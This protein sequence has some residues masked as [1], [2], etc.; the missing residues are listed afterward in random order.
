LKNNFTIF[1]SWQSDLDPKKNKNFISTV[2][3]KAIKKSK[4]HSDKIE[5][6]I[7]IDRDTKNKSGA[8]SI[9]DSIF[10][11][12]DNC[13]IFICDI[14]I[15]NKNWYTG[16]LKKRLTPN[17]NVLIELGYAVNLLGWERIICLNNI[18]ISKNE[19]LPF[20]IRSHRITN[21]NPNDIDS[22]INILKSAIDFTIN[23]YENILTRFNKK[24]H[25]QHD[26]K[27]YHKLKQI[28]SENELQE[29][30]S[31]S[32]NS[33]ISNQYYLDMYDNIE[34]F[35]ETTTNHFIDLEIENNFLEFQKSISNFSSKCS[36]MFR[37]DRNPVNIY[38]LEESGI[39]LSNEEIVKH[40]FNILYIY[41]KEPYQNETQAEAIERRT[42][43][44]NELIEIQK[45]ILTNYKNL[46]MCL[47]KKSYEI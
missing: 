24:N 38:D 45:S 5:L 18:N 42:I 35:Y 17:P 46:I 20:D 22:N 39:V 1:Y 37:E 30:L 16:I 29:S 34:L 19:D 9:S 27:I 7:S 36:E 32:I 15:I 33:T 21:I 10:E 23:D 31:L 28:F 44:I 47:K 40:L 11:K 41:H 8:I 12:I 43:Y 3:N 25:K 13:D 4:K 6:E 2:L 14:S 26:Q